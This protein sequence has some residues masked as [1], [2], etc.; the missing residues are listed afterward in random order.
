MATSEP[1]NG[2]GANVTS[3]PEI[4]ELKKI[5]DE[6]CDKVAKAREDLRLAREECQTG[7][8]PYRETMH[9]ALMDAFIDAGGVLEKTVVTY[10]GCPDGA[11][12][13]V[14][15]TTT[16]WFESDRP[17]YELLRVVNLKKCKMEDNFDTSPTVNFTG[18]TLK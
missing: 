10:D 15:G 17:E 4:A 9:K 18:E 2:I 8:A 11:K 3:I 1:K 7:S 5:S 12:Y 16:N 13:V 14:C 6:L